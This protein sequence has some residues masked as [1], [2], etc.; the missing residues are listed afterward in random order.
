MPKRHWSIEKVHR[1][2]QKGWKEHAEEIIW[3][4][5]VFEENIET[6]IIEWVKKAAALQIWIIIIKGKK[7][8]RVSE[9]EWKVVPGPT[10]E[11]D[12]NSG[13]NIV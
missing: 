12:K 2:N 8:W 10:E 5:S 1:W 4:P 11:S 6:I 9:G 3:P 13:C 7:G